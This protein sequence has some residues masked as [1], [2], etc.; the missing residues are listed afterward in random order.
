MREIELF[1]SFSIVSS[2]E[3]L[4]FKQG[5]QFY[6]LKVS[7]KLFDRSTLKVRMYVSE[8]DYNYSY[9]W[10][11]EKEELIV[12]WDNSP[13][14]PELETFPHHKHLNNDV[15][16]SLEISLEEVLLY[17]QKRLNSSKS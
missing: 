12:R 1:K 11:N 8:Q 9:H 14:H 13:H 6:Y 17:I 4:D 5:N 10:Q 2:C 16:N 7:V 3:I 15:E